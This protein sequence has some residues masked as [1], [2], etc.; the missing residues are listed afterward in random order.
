MLKTLF[1]SS[2]LMGVSLACR[3]A[4][5]PAVPAAASAPRYALPETEEWELATADGSRAY[6]ILVYRPEGAAPPGGFAV[7]TVLD[8]NAL[9][10]GLVEAARATR[11][12]PA[13]PK[14]LMVVAVGYPGDAAYDM[15][16]RSFDLTPVPSS[17]AREARAGF[18]LGGQ[19]EF[20]DFLLDR[21]R[22]EVARRYPVDVKKQS[23]YG[24]SF[25]GLFALYA[26]Y[27]RP[28]A[29]QSVVAA[30]PSIWWNGQSV[31]KE[32]ADFRSRIGKAP[33]AILQ[34][35]LRIL[36]GG[37][38][39]GPMVGDARA[40]ASRM[41]PLS[42]NGLRSSLRVLDDESHMSM[43]AASVSDVLRF[44]ATAP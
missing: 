20:L 39:P 1:L 3:A 19:R 6:R 11:H 35:S 41:E 31:L 2:A 22:G 30:S 12:E 14:G 16:R 34:T 36:V 38:E 24:H 17:A 5:A 44:V 4:D 37:R 25:G 32:E 43:P 29:F 27:T 9:F 23:L 18:A 33:D 28:D 15:R 21:L 10:A 40:L 8:G 26:L 13:G 7:L 42:A